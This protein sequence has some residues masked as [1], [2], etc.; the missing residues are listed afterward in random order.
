MVIVPLVIELLRPRRVVDVGCGDGTWLSIFEE[1][2]VEDILG[3]DGA[4]AKKSLRIPETQF[5]AA[6]LEQ[7]LRLRRQFDLVVSLEVAEHLPADS[8]ETFVGSLT[9]L[10]QFVLFSAAA[11]FQGGTGH[12]NEQWPDYWAELFGKKGYVAV[13]CIRKKVWKNDRVEWWY[14][15]NML[16]FARRDCLESY[17]ALSKAF[18]R[19][20]TKN[21]SIIHPR[22][23]VLSKY[24][25]AGLRTL[26]LRAVLR[27]L[28]LK[29][30]NALKRSLKRF[31][32][33]RE[34]AAP[35]RPCVS[36]PAE[37]PASSRTTFR[38]RRAPGRHGE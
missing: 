3:I 37:D 29:A 2:G 7:P 26:R 23:S 15:Q 5:L 17:P 4:Y 38:S 6:D 8:A 14:A 34:S 19:T 1:N 16:L 21:L 11:P 32:S 9:S 13:D 20:N 25:L 24:S 35:A 28:P 30:G 31:I 12:L 33:R 36:S 22:S 27:V 10:G 18:E